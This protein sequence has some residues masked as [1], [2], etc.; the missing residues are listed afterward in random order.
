MFQSKKVWV[1]CV[2]MRVF[3]WVV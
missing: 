1:F 3:D 2:C